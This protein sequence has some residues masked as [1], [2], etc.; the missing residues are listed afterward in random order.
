LF[1][2]FTRLDRF[3]A[4]QL[5]GGERIR[6]RCKGRGCPFKAKTLKTRKAGTRDATKLVRNARFGAGTVLEAFITESGTVGRYRKLT[7]RDAKQ[8]KLLKR[9]LPPGARKPSK[10]PAGG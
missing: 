10:C 5:A 4:V 8:P 1:A 9:C 7:F 6:L 2:T 3:R